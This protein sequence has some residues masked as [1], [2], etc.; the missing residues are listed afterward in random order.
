ME[1]SQLK[2]KE[3]QKGLYARLNERDT[4]LL[5]RASRSLAEKTL[6][7]GT[8]GN[9]SADASLRLL[10]VSR[11]DK[12]SAYEQ[13][14]ALSASPN[15]EEDLL[16]WV[17]GQIY[18]RTKDREFL[19]KVYPKL[20]QAEIIMQTGRDTEHGGLS[21]VG[22]KAPVGLNCRKMMFYRAL[23]FL[24]A[25]LAEKA[26]EEYFNKKELALAEAINTG[27]WDE[28]NKWYADAGIDGSASGFLTAGS[29]MPLYT[30]IASRD[31]ARR[32]AELGA[33]S[34]KFF[35]G[36]PGIAYDSPEYGGAELF[37]VSAGAEASY[38]AAKGLKQYGY[39][40]I[41]DKIKETMLGWCFKAKEAFYGYYDAKN[42]RGTGGANLARTPVFVI[43]FILNY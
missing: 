26:G 39:D 11:W 21:F 2:R 43:E 14:Y 23:S 7:A 25:E 29:F 30:G 22:G 1:Y 15:S 38:F 9:Y 6:S 40:E 33:D 31:R 36:M 5:E 34:G 17:C 13:A 10:A 37:A 32:M 28:T 41:S 24:A 19:A 4:L 27:L 12:E 20:K 42:G 35:P 3:W 16:S 8:A 18:K